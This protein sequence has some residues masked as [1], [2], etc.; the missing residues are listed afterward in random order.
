MTGAASCTEAIAEH[1]PGLL[2][3]TQFRHLFYVLDAILCPLVEHK[4]QIALLQ[5]WSSVCSSISA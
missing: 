2:S 4:A 3:Q 1:L 5:I